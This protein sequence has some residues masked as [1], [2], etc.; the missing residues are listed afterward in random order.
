MSSSIGKGRHLMRPA[1]RITI[2]PARAGAGASPILW[3]PSLGCHG[4]ASARSATS[5]PR[6]YP[7]HSFKQQTAATD[8]PSHAPGLLCVPGLHNPAALQQSW[9]RKWRPALEARLSALSLATDD[10]SLIRSLDSLLL[11]LRDVLVLSS[12]CSAQCKAAGWRAAAEEVATAC[13]KYQGGLI[14]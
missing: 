5:T 11:L 8:P 10:P 3:L 14:H 1:G 9:R 13:R 6:A 2:G 4:R 12:H 7:P